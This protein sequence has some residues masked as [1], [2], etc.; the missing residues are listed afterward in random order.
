MKAPGTAGPDHL[1]LQ[2][3]LVTKIGDSASLKHIRSKAYL[4]YF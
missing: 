1:P 3:I 2:V 4:L